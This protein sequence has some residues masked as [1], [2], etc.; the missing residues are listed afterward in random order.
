MG[1]HPG[2]AGGLGVFDGGED[3]DGH[4][5]ED[6]RG[7]RGADG[8]PVFQFAEEVPLAVG[9][10]RKVLAAANDLDATVAALV[11]AFAKFADEKIIVH[12]LGDLV[13]GGQEARAARHFQPQVIRKKNDL[14]HEGALTGYP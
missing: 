2:L 1:L 4:V 13:G 7:A 14:W 8:R 6:A 10:R 11:P 12:Q 3:A 9:Q 5:A